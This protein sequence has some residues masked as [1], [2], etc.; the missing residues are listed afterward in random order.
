MNTRRLQRLVKVLEKAHVRDKAER[1]AGTARFFDM[2]QF[3]QQNIDNK[4]ITAACALGCAVMDPVFAKAGLKLKPWMTK[5]DA[6]AAGFTTRPCDVQ[7]KQYLDFEAATAFFGVEHAV[8]A[9]LFDPTSY[10][11]HDSLITPKDVAR[12]VQYLLKHGE[13]KFCDKFHM[14]DCV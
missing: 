9:R 13:R 7:Y 2:A 4:C 12:R 14:E 10:G 3:G 8:S 6:I 11:G 1:K 5:K